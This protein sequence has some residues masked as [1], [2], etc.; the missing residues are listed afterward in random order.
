MHTCARPGK[1]SATTAA[2]D[3]KPADLVDLAGPVALIIGNEGNGVPE[4]SPRSATGGH[5]PLPR[6][7][8]EPE[9]RSGGQCDALR[10]IAA[11]A[12]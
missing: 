3:A 12:G 7:G 4:I 10:G 2:Q 11:T 9:R 8:G 6:A 1:N 5:D